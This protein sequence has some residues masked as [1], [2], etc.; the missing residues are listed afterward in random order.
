MASKRKHPAKA[1]STFGLSAE[2]IERIRRTAPR[3][4]VPVLY[5]AGAMLG[6]YPWRPA[7]AAGV[8]PPLPTPCA[9]GPCGVMSGNTPFVQ[10]GQ[11]NLPT[12]NGT[13]M[14]INQLS[15]SAI[16][17]WKDF[18]IANGYSVKFQQPGATSSAL[19]R[20]WSGDPSVIA[21]K[22]SANGQIYLV[23]QNG[24]LFANG[25]QVDVG[26]LTATTL[27]IDDDLYTNGLFSKNNIVTTGSAALPPVFI[28]GSAVAGGIEVD[29]GANL[30]AASG[31]RIML[32]GTK[33]INA[34]KISAPDGQVVLGAGD[35]VYLAASTD[36]ALRGVL[37]EVKSNDAQNS[38]G[39]VINQ[40]QI[41]SDRGNV[42]LAAMVVNQAGMVTA[43]T[44]VSANGSIDLIAGDTSNPNDSAFYNIKS[45]TEPV[46]LLPNNGGTLTLAPG[47]VTQV[48]ADPTDTGTVS[49]QNASSFL[50]SQV[51]LVGKEIALEGNASIRAPAGN[52]DLTAATDPFS[53]VISPDQV[54]GGSDGASRIYLDSGSSIDVS[55][56]NNVAVPVTDNLISVRLQSNDLQ[57]DP[58]QRDGILHG[59]T[60]VVDANKGSTLFDVTP[61]VNNVT[62]TAPEEMAHGGSIKLDSNGDVVT[63]EGSMLNV[64]GGSIAYQSGMGPSTTKLIGADGRI[65]DITTAPKNIQYVGFA[66]YYSYTDQK[67]G[68]TRTWSTQSYYAG[69]DQGAP[70]GSLSILAP[71]MYLRG[72]LLA[73]TV[74]GPY[75]RFPSSLPLGGTFVLG[76]SGQ[77]D[78]GSASLDF[79]APGVVFADGAQDTLGDE[80]SFDPSLSALPASYTQNTTVSPTQL[81]DSGFSNIDVYS[82]GAVS[83]PAGSAL[84]LANGGS[85]TIFGQSVEIDGKI[86]G[87]G[88]NVLLQ[89]TSRT[90]GAFGSDLGAH[91]VALGD[92]AA[93][94]VSGDWVNDSPL[95]GA[96]NETT[97]TLIDGGNVTLN[98]QNDV[99]LGDNTS[100][101]V[102]GGGWVDSKNQLTAGSAGSITLAADV[103]VSGTNASPPFTGTISAGAGVQLLGASLAPGKGGTLSM[104]AGWITVGHISQSAPDNKLPGELV[105]APDFLNYGAGGFANYNFTGI[106]GVEI[107][108][109][110]SN[111]SA[112]AAE[113][114]P[115]FGNL[116]N[117]PVN[118]YPIQT[119][120]V[121]TQNDL[122]QATGTKLSSFTQLQ[123][124][125]V[126]QR[127]PASV[128]F[129]SNP[130]SSL[131]PD[132]GLGGVV[133]AKG[134][135]ITTDAQGSVTLADQGFIGNVE[136]LG[137]ISAL[138]GSINL[139]LASK[140][141]VFDNPSDPGFID[142]QQ[143]LIGSTATLSATG[144]AD[145]NT[146]NPNHYRQGSVLD[147]GKISLQAYKGFVVVDA[148]AT[149]DVSGASGTVD[150]IGTRSVTP[151]AVAGDAGQ[152]EID[153]REGI[154]LQGT[155]KG[156]A[157]NLPGA[158]GGSLTVGLDLF[159]HAA[160]NAF[161]GIPPD[162]ESAERVLTLT[163]EPAAS[164][165]QDLVPGTAVISTQSLK[166]GG[167]DSGFDSIV[168]K[169]TDVIAF[170]NN[171]SL[172]ARNN[173]TLDAPVLRG[174]D[175]A[176][177][178]LS[179]PHVAFGNYYN[180]SGATEETPSIVP[181]SQSP[182][183]L[184][185]NGQLIDVR[186][187]SMLDNF[188]GATLNSAGDIQLG[189][190][191]TVDASAPFAAAALYTGGDLTLNAAQIYPATATHFDIGSSQTVVIHGTGTVPQTP[192][193]AGGDLTI[194]AANIDQGGVLR[195]PMGQ[196]N[197][198]GPDQGTDAQGNALPRG[199]S[200]VLEPD[201]VTSVSANGLLI[202]Y[203]STQ[204]GQQWIYS[205]LYDP[206][207]NQGSAAIDVPPSKQITIDARDISIKQDNKGTRAQVDLAGG[208]DLYAYEFIRGPGGSKDVL[209]PGSATYQYAIVPSLGSSA[210][211]LDAQYSG[212][213]SIAAGKNIYLSGVPGIA[214]GYYTLLPARYAL[215]PGA[216]AIQIVKPDSDL[217]AGTAVK[218]AD[219]SYLASA[220]FG[221]TGT[222]IL[223]SRTSTVVLAPDSVVRTQSQ[224]NDSYANQ[225][226]TNAAAASGTVAPSLPADAGALQLSASG[227][228]GLD[229]GIDFT[230]GS[231]VSGKDADGNPIV[232]Q[233]IGGVASITAPDIEVV[234]TVQ[235]GVGGSALQLGADALNALGAQTLILGATKATGSSGDT[236]TVGAQS[237]ELSNSSAHTLQAPDVI[238]AATS[239]VTLDSGSAVSSSGSLARSPAALL[240]DG[241]GALLR[242]SSGT[243]TAFS[244]GGLSGTP[245]ATLNVAAG[246]SVNAGGSLILD[247]AGNT[248]VDPLAD[249]RSPAVTVSS[250]RV[251]L[252][253]VPNGTPGLNLTTTLLDSLRS[254]TDL[255]VTSGSSIDFWGAVQLG[256]LDSATGKPVLKSVTFDAAGLGGHGSGDKSV[257]AGTIALNNSAGTGSAFV[258][259]PDGSGQLLLTAKADGQ[260]G[261]GQITL[262]SG[263]K[264]I[265]GFGGVS[266]TADNQIQGQGTGTL[267]LAG[268]GDLTLTT[269]R[270]GTSGGAD[271]SIADDDGAVTINAVSPADTLPAAA[272]GGKLAIA[273]TA[274]DQNGRIDLPAGVLALEATGPGGLQLGS[275]SAIN[276]AGVSQAFYDTYASAPGGRVTLLA[277]QGDV[278]L[279]GGASIDVSGA[280]SP[281]GKSNSDAGS[282]NVSAANGRFLVD[283]GANLEGDAADGRQKGGFTL[284]VASL[285]DP[286]NNFSTLNTSLS[287]GH[288]NGAVS[289]RVRSGDVIIAAG[290]NVRAS[291]FVLAADTGSITVAGSIDTT[292][293]D[294]VGTDGGAIAVWAG[295]DMTLESGAMLKADAGKA[296]AGQRNPR[297][298]DVTLSAGIAPSADGS[299]S[300]DL[301]KDATIESHGATPAD[302]G[303]VTVRAHTTAD[304]TDVKITEIASTI[305]ASKPVV[306][307]GVNV[308]TAST[309][310]GT[311]DAAGSGYTV[312]TSG[313]LYADAQKLAGNAQ[314]I[315]SR[316]QLASAELRPGIEVRSTGDLTVDDNWNLSSWHFNETFGSGG[317]AHTIS[318]P[319]DLTLRAQGDLI[320][321]AS[322]SDGFADVTP[323]ATF[324]LGAGVESAS[325]RLTAGADPDAANPL[326]VASAAAL[327]AQPAGGTAGAGDFVLNAGQLIRTGTGSIDIAAGHDVQFVDQTSVIYT[328]GVPDPIDSSL[329]PVPAATGRGG[330]I[331]A[332]YPDSGGDIAINAGN[333][334]VGAPT[335]QL[336]SDWMWRRG[337]VNSNGAIVSGQNTSWWIMFDQFQQGVG[338]LGGGNIVAHAGG[339]ITNLSA[340]VP[341]TGRLK[342]AGGS[343]P[344]LNNLVVDGGGNLAIDAG[345]DIDSGIFEADRGNARISAGGSLA[346]GRTDSQTNPSPTTDHPVF[347]I[348]VFGYGGG[349]FDVSARSDLT[350]D[351]ALNATVLPEA[352]ANQAKIGSG[353]TSYF[354]TFPDYSQLDLVS[355]AGNVLLNNDADA[356]K[357]AAPVGKYDSRYTNF[358]DLTI[359]PPTLNVAAMSGN[360]TADTLTL[361]PNAEGNLNLLAYGGI[362]A[363]NNLVVSEVDPAQEPNILLPKVSL[364]TGNGGTVEQDSLGDLPLLLPLQSLHQGDGLPIHIVATTG[365]ID[366][367]NGLT[368]GT[369]IFP[370]PAE[371][372]AGGD[373]VNALYYGKNLDASD[374]TQFIAGGDIRFDTAINSSNQLVGN[375]QGIDIAG[376]GTVELLT[377][378]NVD[379]GNSN[380]VVT[381]G[382]LNDPRLPA[383]GASLVIGSGL[384]NN[385]DGSLRQ[386]DYANFIAKYLAP[387]PGGTES[388]YADELTAYMAQVEPVDGGSLTYDE[389]LAAFQALPAKQQLPLIAKVLSEEL[390]ATGLAHSTDGSGYDRGYAAI[391]ALFP[392]TDEQ[393]N[394]LS[395]KGDI[396]LSFSQIKTEQ[397]GDINL[398]AP[399]GSVIVGL[400][401]PPAALAGAKESAPPLGVSADAKLG[402]LVLDQGAIR[403]F[404]LDDFSVNTSRILTL[405]GGDIV[406][407]ASNGDIDAGSGAK[408]ASAAPPPIIQTDANGNVFVNP[409]GAV[410]GSGIGQLLTKPGIQPGIVNLIAPNGTVDAG[411][412]GIRVAGNLNIAAQ[413][414]IGADNISVGGTATGVPVSNAGA[415]A[416][417]LSGANAL[418]DA[419]KNTA[420]ALSQ[421]LAENA[422]NNESLAESIKPSFVTVKLFC[423]GKDCDIE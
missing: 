285:D 88:A 45:T 399:G 225:F 381:S 111:A 183:T 380:G 123:D 413:R 229:G 168:F 51:T 164:L 104:Q 422:A 288:F 94:S 281:D 80:F 8:R 9:G 240:V 85:L 264:Q 172:T 100:I 221:V 69:Y 34:G 220:R 398:M 395:Y 35:Q 318:A 252:G 113:S 40:G 213:T 311:T 313:Q 125:G 367:G 46:T 300:I 372:V 47:S 271:Q 417:A 193:S 19:N 293:G 150:V 368:Q 419:G 301:Q 76:D 66:D 392:T 13:N 143:L 335:A 118:L 200:I 289:E 79:R 263:A 92:G 137:N 231:F 257:I 414:V 5:L 28:S 90:I 265:S 270:V 188:A 245:Q 401:N 336:I 250:S 259:T 287:K 267:T 278:S 319:V 144:Y 170:E 291:S 207:N 36:P 327:A 145:I 302:D 98:A 360:V 156:Q 356:L 230:R 163:S 235:P 352:A 347:P 308:Y 296:V 56:L 86:T 27:N 223:D 390:S 330:T 162:T 160:T 379:L 276:V 272:L 353:N 364:Q 202:P 309:L 117:D 370:K 190:A 324:G 203:G 63:R 234:D 107:G 158:A 83:L 251:S 54:D 12:V 344:S 216:Y 359:Y 341:S 197:L 418:G 320:F 61:Y 284:D 218:Q 340:V 78:L 50:P 402:L 175:G 286:L 177:V 208:G 361:Y 274:I 244:R 334:I 328:A 6:L 266:M 248:T 146:L 255:T 72:D 326:A 136:I 345:G 363:L 316:L 239:N 24:I 151:T 407:W 126:L 312:S 173:L 96:Q 325:Y 75:Q 400:P 110:G 269:A 375:A 2:A 333:D 217:E 33:V 21:G 275:G 166:N 42:T 247:A 233:G 52:V 314:A 346:S 174:A 73:Q 159:N 227:T 30:Q 317:D 18:N 294:A 249:V 120:F 409:V 310:G 55:G 71:E 129:T 10:S 26:S 343:Q 273:G 337:Q 349:T 43:T 406:L 29:A 405:Q 396:N 292:G 11:V 1:S 116:Y 420:E 357:N 215:L 31:G 260:S 254:L 258:S 119:N 167:F 282:L 412:A 416:G 280:S 268:A 423:L 315:A 384:G 323:S 214:A 279:A 181:V 99:R 38:P 195:A 306:V 128:S 161:Y 127:A 133:L 64:S 49:T 59:A 206:Q 397:G 290:D 241:D 176:Q 382:S 277:D 179:A 283:A 81:A 44:S 155:L 87:A 62:H 246:A 393:G 232:Q 369:E 394:A 48:V 139:Q 132:S 253:D 228:L 198:L 299:G 358:D 256:T 342:G 408:S 108:G 140:D 20:I 331:A 37:I 169:S 219:G 222:D 106:N 32:L 135:S 138:A 191:Q 242:V 338:A 196:I 180:E 16:L 297:G 362:T 329:F 142:G 365:D 141:G 186:G 389:A 411:E 351:A 383:G 82:N 105:L 23:N 303:T 41:T 131:M 147:G 58:L 415:L 210:A 371:I 378:R 22:L 185:V 84:T 112:A 17:N 391:D 404:A 171:V 4:S 201:S 261:S 209:D 388:R 224:F 153:A 3:A 355:T 199:G 194:T 182:A 7:Q 212:G 377:G 226:F 298:G 77:S 354:Y 60:V 121:F 14:T 134:S 374:V 410:S 366:F 386:A 97:P 93:I 184:Q 25:A 348:L 101:D 204:N 65:Y 238:L 115:P 57:D 205:W 350:I 15:N 387:G 109:D 189:Y 152:V 124:L 165:S 376:P 339:D 332:A 262:G 307:E 74:L 91:D 103:K 236:L 322:L 385:A 187:S 89:S 305:D 321:N 39:V 149:I 122:A 102:S 421:S 114:G 211:P 243:Q 178:A 304:G 68:V 95:L 70:A 403:G 157:A 192:L 130:T 373:I 148:G 295:R 154:V 67:W 237:V 53:K